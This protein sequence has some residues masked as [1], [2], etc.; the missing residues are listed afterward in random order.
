M[1][2]LEAFFCDKNGDIIGKYVT[3]TGKIS[4]KYRKS[5][6]TS[7]VIDTWLEDKFGDDWVS[8]VRIEKDIE[9]GVKVLAGKNRPMNHFQKFV[10]QQ[11][12]HLQ[13][14]ERKVVVQTV[15]V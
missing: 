12:I 6:V 14:Q 9:R 10:S 3:A 8:G 5:G 11:L 4:S 1:C 7:E 13:K 15:C 2:Y